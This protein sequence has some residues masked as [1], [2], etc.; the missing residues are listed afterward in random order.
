VKLLLLLLPI[1]QYSTWLALAMATTLVSATSTSRPAFSTIEPSLTQ[2][3]AASATATPLSP[4]SNVQGKAF[5][6]IIQI[7]LE[8]TVRGA[9]L[10]EATGINHLHRTTTK[11]P[12]TQTCNGWPPR[13]SP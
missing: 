5:N 12:Q 1:M 10:P 3:E 6:R 4:T 11:R 13:G 9:S 2:I 7:W 8:N